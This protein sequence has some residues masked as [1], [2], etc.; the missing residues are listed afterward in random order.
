MSK[1]IQLFILLLWII[2]F[3]ITF[4]IFL[5]IIHPFILIVY[6]TFFNI[7]IC[8]NISMWHN[9]YIYSILLFL[10]IIRG[11]LI[12]FIYFSRLIANEQIKNTFNL[13]LF[14]LFTLNSLI[15]IFYI[16]KNKNFNFYF[17][18]FSILK[19]PSINF[20][21]SNKLINLINLYN[22][23]NRNLT[24]LRIFFILLAFFTIIKIN[25]SS[26]SISLRKI[27]SYE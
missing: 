3:F 24:I 8:I 11:L 4:L 13:K 2:L 6:I 23:P 15:Y 1:L 25:A 16:I 20:I 27:K 19:I 26:H 5:K 12:I 17:F 7:I 14:F 9:N 10:I 18:N 21:F 22:Y